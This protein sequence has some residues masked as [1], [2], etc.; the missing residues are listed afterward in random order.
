MYANCKIRILGSFHL[1]GNC[2]ELYRKLNELV[3]FGIVNGQE[4]K[5]IFEVQPDFSKMNPST[6]QQNLGQIRFMVRKIPK[7]REF[8]SFKSAVT[9]H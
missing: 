2:S 9:V 8:C 4:P 3:S 5:E 6:F 1:M 7:K